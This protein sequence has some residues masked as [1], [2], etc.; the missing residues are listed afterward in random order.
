MYLLPISLIFF[1]INPSYTASLNII[2]TI[3][4]YNPSHLLFNYRIAKAL[5][6]A[7]HN[8]TAIRVEHFIDLS[9]VSAPD[10]IT[11]YLLQTPLTPEETKVGERVFQ[12]MS[13][14][15][16][17]AT[18]LIG[19]FG[20][21]SDSAITQCAQLLG[22]SGLLKTLSGVKFDIGLTHQWDFCPHYLYKHLGVNKVAIQ[23]A[24]SSWTI[25][26][27]YPAAIP[28]A[29]SFIP[30][31]MFSRDSDVMDFWKRVANFLYNIVNLRFF[32]RL[33]L[34][35]EYRFNWYGTHS[36][37]DL[38]RSA[39]AFYINGEMYLEF[40]RP[41]FH[42][43][44][45]L[46]MLGYNHTEISKP[47]TSEWAKIM[48][49]SQMGVVIFSLGSLANTSFM[50]DEM[51]EGMA[52]AFVNLTDE[53]SVIWKLENPKP[54][55]QKLTNVHTV[56]WMPQ[57]ELLAHPKTKLFISHCGYNSFLEAAMLGVPILGIPLFADQ[58]TN[59][60]KVEKHKIGVA[61]MDKLRM[62]DPSFMI[63]K[64]REVLNNQMYSSNAK[65]I[66]RMMRDKIVGNENYFIKHFELLNKA[67]WLPNL[68]AAQNLNILKYY[69]IDVIC[70][71]F[72]VVLFPLI[73]VYKCKNL[74]K[75]GMF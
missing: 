21:V 33:L 61:I 74:T 4:G 58:P 49:S 9:H 10:S 6:N 2:L 7:G 41:I 12:A 1:T 31:P 47:L 30:E 50:P 42:G 53:Y 11:E 44:R 37:M 20:S 5:V 59:A 48:D 14:A 17:S 3:E 63:S 75:T 73:S 22:P 16:I 35:A 55:I 28:V 56:E 65:R 13:F 26:M 24:L 60:L 27:S 68:S 23:S 36:A 19:T 38:I 70:A 25:W 39:Q 64:I 71:V 67:K 18:K 69:C 52:Q 15:P 62:T 57:K 51:I 72:F 34:I 54:W 45:Y 29:P 32:L 40:P 66:S 43:T 46:G 8:V